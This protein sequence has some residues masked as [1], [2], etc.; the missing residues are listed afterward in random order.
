[1]RSERLVV[2][3]RNKSG[4]LFCER[5]KRSAAGLARLLAKK[6]KGIISSDRWSVYHQLKHGM[7][8]CCGRSVLWRVRTGNF[9]AG[10]LAQ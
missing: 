1:M 3:R 9:E 6:I 7:S 5:S 4:R 10:F 2:G 8:D